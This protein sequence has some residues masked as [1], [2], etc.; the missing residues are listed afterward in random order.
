VREFTFINPVSTGKQSVRE[1]LCFRGP[2]GGKKLS[3][4]GEEYLPKGRLRTSTC[5]EREKGSEIIREKKGRWKKKKTSEKEAIP[6]PKEAANPLR[7]KAK[8]PKA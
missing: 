2:G 6:P 7:Q 3:S 5:G 8:A 1:N 4:R